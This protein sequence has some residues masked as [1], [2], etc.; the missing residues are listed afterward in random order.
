MHLVLF[1][2]VIKDALSVCKDIRFNSNVRF[3]YSHLKQLS[4]IKN[5]FQSFKWLSAGNKLVLSRKRFWCWTL[6]ILLKNS[7]K[8][9]KLAKEHKTLG[10]CGGH[11]T[12]PLKV[13]HKNRW[14]HQLRESQSLKVKLFSLNIFSF[15]FFWFIFSIL[16]Q[17]YIVLFSSR[18][19]TLI[20]VTYCFNF[21]KQQ[22][23][24]SNCIDILKSKLNFYLLH[25][26]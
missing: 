9:L 3:L 20:H 19:Q 4:Q 16:S 11:M 7:N 15:L 22:I 12:P 1:Q 14:A 26:T 2:N 5:P 18:V 17:K 13:G 10:H 23:S 8:Y 24:L 21:S 25:L 6:T